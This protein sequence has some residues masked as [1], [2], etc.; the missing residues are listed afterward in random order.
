MNN[1]KIIASVVILI[2]ILFSIF[3]KD[4]KDSAAY[5]TLDKNSKILAFGDSLTYGYGVQKSFSYPSQLQ[6]KTNLHVVNAGVSGEVS[7]DGLLRLPNLL[8][9]KPSLVI[10]CHGGNDILRKKSKAKLKSNLLKMIKLIKA[11]GAEVLLIGVP[12]FS[13][14]GFSTLPLYEEVAKETD[15]MLEDEVLS[16]IESRPSLKSDNI[17]PNQS[18]YEMMADA[19]IE[20]LRQHN[21]L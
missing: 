7:A 9:H 14:F 5:K 21:F 20:I 4:S 1:I 12:D 11:S 3:I 19:V 15:V 18:G 6:M 16:Y 17:H 8:K 10:L 2:S 13:I